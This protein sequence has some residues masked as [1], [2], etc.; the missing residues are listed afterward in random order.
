MKAVVIVDGE[1]HE[2]Q[3]VPLPEPAA[4][5]IR[6]RVEASGVCGTD[7]HILH[8]L[9]PP[10]SGRPLIM[11]HEFAGVVDAV[12]E[13]V[14]DFAKGDRVAADPNVHCGQCE[15][16]RR[17]AYNLCDEWAALGI[18]RQGALAEYVCVSAEGAVRLPDSVSTTAGALIEPLSCAVHAFNL[19][20]VRPDATMVI[21]GG[22]M[23][24]LT[25]LALARQLG[26]RVSVVEIHEARR[27]IALEM[28]AAEAT[29]TGDQLTRQE[30]DYVV[31]ATGVPDVVEE[32]FTKLRTR[33]TFMQVGMTPAD[34]ELKIHPHDIFQRELRIV[35][36]FSVADA[37][38][39]SGRLIESLAPSLEKLVTHRFRL[40]QFDDALAAMSSPDA[41]KVH[42]EPHL[43]L[44]ATQGGSAS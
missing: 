34:F 17:G 16:C 6:V 30:F 42:V 4:G 18:T 2:I 10:G 24:G 19:S 12:G 39:A 43:P 20:D 40:D 13:A 37:Y 26:H 32:A 14:T 3:D 28:G 44:A 15:W 41:L 5:E 31:E 38:P 8:G 33:G 1:N 11:G 36:S 25:C 23:M 22:G 7:L 29:E 35:G 27:R 9:Y 21:F